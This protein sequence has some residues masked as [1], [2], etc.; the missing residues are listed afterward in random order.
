MHN[1]VTLAAHWPTSTTVSTTKS[2][3]SDLAHPLDAKLVCPLDSPASPTLLTGSRPSLVWSFKSAR[4]LLF[5]VVYI[6]QP[7]NVM[8]PFKILCVFLIQWNITEWK[9]TAFYSLPVFIFIF[10]ILRDWNQVVLGCDFKKFYKW[11]CSI[12]ELIKKD[13][14]HSTMYSDPQGE[15]HVV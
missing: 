13:W 1:R 2:E 3:L 10:K 8:F 15:Y 12:K 6:N 9:L 11:P 14:T 7:N 4:L 5:L